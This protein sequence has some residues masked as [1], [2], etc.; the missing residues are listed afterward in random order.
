MTRKRY[1][2][3]L[4]PLYGRWLAMNR[5]CNNP[6]DDN[7]PHYGGRGICIDSDLSEFLE[8]ASYVSSLPNYDP[9]NK[10]VD[11]IDNNK[12]Y[13]KGNLR[14][15]TCDVQT[16]NQRASGKGFNKYT[17]INW[18]ICKNRWIARITLQGKTLLSKSCYT[19]REAFDIR[20]QFII[21][22]DLP[23]T[24]QVWTN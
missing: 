20:K 11:R 24:I 13:S 12:N 6:N 17:G 15:T 16:A 19:E 7:Y 21:D 5:R 9:L 8:Y 2:N 22:N 1:G 10:T 18:N 14:W 3:E 4:H 23:H